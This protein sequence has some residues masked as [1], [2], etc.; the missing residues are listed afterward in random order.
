LAPCEDK[1]LDQISRREIGAAID[2]IAA[3]AP[4]S[5]NRTLAYTKAMFAWAEGRGH[6]DSNPVRSISKP[7]PEKSRDR[8]PNLKELVCIFSAADRLA[9]PFGHAIQLLIMTATR[10]DEV[11]RMKVAEVD[12]MTAGEACWTIPSER[13]KNGRAIRIA[14]PRQAVHILERALHV[15]P[16]GSQ[17]I[18]STSGQAPVSGWS[19]AKK[20][21]DDLAAEEA[22]RLGES[23]IVPWRIHDFR[24]SFATYAC[25]AL[26]ID[27][28][29][30]DRCLNHVGS[31]TMSTVSRVYIR[32]Q[33]FD[34]RR[35]ALQ[36]WT[37]LLFAELP[38]RQTECQGEADHSG[39]DLPVTVHASQS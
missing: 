3:R 16:S 6:I 11:S 37:D 9:Y 27:P 29:T 32:N 30:A 2:R 12:L 10:R 23:P 20:R 15:R 31:S 19:K 7:A 38:S 21:L 14:L 18:F 8:T 4:I 5:A 13:S 39:G 25:D 22:T 34:Q 26:G 28:A 1:I 36:A 33:M 24:R 35:D 17:W